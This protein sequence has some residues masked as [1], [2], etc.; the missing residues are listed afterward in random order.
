MPS[1]L[2]SD[3]SLSHF[4]VWDRKQNSGLAGGPKDGTN[5]PKVYD[6]EGHFVDQLPT[7]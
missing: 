5:A 6:N 7:N 1:P 2:P 4:L 3:K